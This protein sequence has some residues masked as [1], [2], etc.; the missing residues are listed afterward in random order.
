[1]KIKLNYKPGRP[2]TV[3]LIIYLIFSVSLFIVW[4]NK[5]VYSITGDEPHYLVMASGIANEG[6][7]EQTLPYKVEFQTK[8]IF[9]PGM[10]SENENPSP[11]NS[12]TVRGPHGLFNVHGLGLPLLL[13]VPFF[14]GGVVGSKLFMILL[15]A[16]SVVATWKISGIFSNQSKVRFLSTLATCIAFPLIPASSQIYP[17]LLAGGIALGGLYWVMV[18]STQRTISQDCLLAVAISFL[19]WLQIKFSVTAIIL[20]AAV[21]L[22]IY[23]ESKNIRR[24][25]TI[26]LITVLSFVMLAIYNYYAFGK[27]SGPY[28]S[29][30]LEFSKTSLMVLAGLLLDQNQG[31]LFQNPIMFSGLLAIGSLMHFDKKLGMLWLLVFLSLIVPN[32]L[33]PNWYGG[34]SFSGRFEWAAAMVFILPTMLGLT[35]LASVNMKIFRIS[36]LFSI[37]LQLYFVFLSAHGDINLYNKPAKRCLM[38]IQFFI[39]HFRPYCLLFIMLIGH[40]LTYQT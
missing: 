25:L 9:S 19:P 15:C 39:I 14:L 37:I 24:I 30:S 32:S 11:E 27:C 4:K 21:L 6:V 10:A 3:L 35:K 38:T 8:K 20:I 13:A 34:W 7:F 28:L 5:K 17:D 33:H 31:L 29:G 1:M 22:K 23:F 16:T 36:I 2:L 26:S 18:A 12:H 40:M